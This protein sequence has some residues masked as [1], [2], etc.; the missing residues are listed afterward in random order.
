MKRPKVKQNI[1]EAQ[2]SADSNNQLNQHIL[3]TGRGGG[4]M[5]QLLTGIWN[6]PRYIWGLCQNLFWS[7]IL[8]QRFIG[9]IMPVNSVIGHETTM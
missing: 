8:Q 9:Y 5:P 4:N 7:W 2:T 3:G 1:G 6:T